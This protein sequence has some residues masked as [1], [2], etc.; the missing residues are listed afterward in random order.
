MEKNKDDKYYLERMLD[1]INIIEDYLNNMEKINAHMEP[2]NQYADGVI[3]KFIQ[4]REEAKNLSD[5]LLSNNPELR[6]NINPLIGFRNRL[7][8]DYVNLSYTFFDEIIDNDLPALKNEIKKSINKY[9][10]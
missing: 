10:K 5:D 6:N 9:D 4:L 7:T 1:Y 2:N 3:Y 8:H